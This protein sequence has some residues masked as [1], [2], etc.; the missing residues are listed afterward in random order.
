MPAPA[1]WLF[2]RGL[3]CWCPFRKAQFGPH[4]VWAV[5]LPHVFDNSTCFFHKLC[6]YGQHAFFQPQVVFQPDADMASG[7]DGRGDKNI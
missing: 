6:V 1:V 2:P 4:R 5:Y 7:Q 3:S